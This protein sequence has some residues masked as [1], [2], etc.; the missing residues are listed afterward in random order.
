MPSKRED[1]VDI[2]KGFAIISVVLGHISFEY[3]EIKLLPISTLTAWLWHVPVFFMIGGF[4]LS[5]EKLIKPGAFI[6][7]KILKLYLPIMYIY[8]PAVLLHN[9]LLDIGFY[10][11]DID[12]GDK[13]VSY[14]NIKDYIINIVKTLFLAGREPVMGAMWF[15]YVLFMALCMMSIV[16]WICNRFADKIDNT[17]LAALLLLI[18]GVAG[19]IL[20][21][22]FD[23]TIPRCNNVFTAAWL[24]FVGMLLRKKLEIKFDNTYCFIISLIVFYS[25]AVLRGNVSLNHN[26]FDDLV[27]LTLSTISA[28]YVVCFISKKLG[29]W[30]AKSLVVVGRD[31]FWI[32]GLHFLSFKICSV[33]LNCFGAEH[34]PALLMPSCGQNI[35]LLLYFLIG[36]ILLPLIVIYLFRKVK[37]LITKNNSY[38]NQNPRRDAQKV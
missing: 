27:S 37:S 11:T 12:Y 5:E 8:I 24:I 32:M 34:N 26:T 1:W 30:F 13:Y 38:D 25:F 36:G 17:K 6:K 16:Y 3:P 14:W 31:S 23:F 22:K 10:S 4:F 33:L 7:G 35:L 20:T 9:C 18:G 2:A 21:N 29:G 28:L 15:A 19:S